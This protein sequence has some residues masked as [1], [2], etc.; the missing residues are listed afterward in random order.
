MCPIDHQANW[1]S[2]QDRKKKLILANNERENK[3]RK[4][5]EH[6]I[7]QLAHIKQEQIV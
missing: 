4:E 6:Q 2:I 1:T 7:G 3:S 5:H